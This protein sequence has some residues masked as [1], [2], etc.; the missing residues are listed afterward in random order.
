MYSIRKIKNGVYYYF[1][2]NINS[3]IECVFIE[4]YFSRQENQKICNRIV[5]DNTVELIL[6]DKK[7][8]RRFSDKKKTKILHSHISGLKTT[9]QDILLDGSPFISIRFKPEIIYQLTTIPAFE[10][11]N[12]A[13]AP[14][15]VFGKD[16][17][18]FEDEL[19]N[20]TTIHERLK[21]IENYF[22]NKMIKM[23]VKEDTLF[24]AARVFMDI[25]HGNVILN[26]LS[27]KLNVSQKTLENKFN[28]SIGI[29][30]KAYCRLIRF[31]SCVKNYNASQTTLTNLAYE[32]NFS[33]QSHFIKEVR[34]FTGL[35]PRKYFSQSQGIQEDIF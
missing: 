12:E 22:T 25:N 27:S 24:K 8:E 26:H 32:N 30:P 9:W 3:L 10:F 15:D 28:N 33:D 4:N 2:G 13:I 31:I 20:L 34:R 17:V 14:S 11:R 21:L 18:H 7:F 16:F 29:T 19:F 1:N 23:E 5:P 6:T 35:S